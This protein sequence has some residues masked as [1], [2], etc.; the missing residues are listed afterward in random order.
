MFALGH[1]F[2]QMLCTYERW[3]ARPAGLKRLGPLL[4]QPLTARCMRFRMGCHGL[5]N[6]IGRRA[7]TPRLQR[8]CHHCDMHTIGHERHVIFECTA[9]QLV[10]DQFPVLFRGDILT[11]K[12][13]MWQD[14]TVQVGK[15]IMQCFASMRENDEGGCGSSNQP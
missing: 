13:C 8:T 10:R 14:N 5:A 11:L 12:D 2:L 9:L 3:F 6:N 1:A 7:G 15:F 4:Q